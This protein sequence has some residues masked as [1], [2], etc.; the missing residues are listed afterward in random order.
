MKYVFLLLAS[1]IFSFSYAQSCQM[2]YEGSLCQNAPIK[3]TGDATG[4]SHSFD[5]NGEGTSSGSRIAT[6]RFLTAGT[7]MIT[8]ITTINSVQCTSVLYLVIKS[9]PRIVLK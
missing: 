5:F 8:Y 3:F 4:T 7:K 9:A 2:L 6:H 1:L